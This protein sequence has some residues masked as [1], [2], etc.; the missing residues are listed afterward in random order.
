MLSPISPPSLTLLASCTSL[1]MDV[2]SEFDLNIKNVDGTP[3]VSLSQKM[4]GKDNLW[5]STWE[6][7]HD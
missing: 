3:K 5:V 4:A 6:T 7:L 1:P 2:A